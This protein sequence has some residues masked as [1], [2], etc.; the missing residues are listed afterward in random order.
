[1]NIFFFLKKLFKLFDYSSVKEK[2]KKMYFYVTKG[3]FDT[4]SI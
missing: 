3:I 1:M 4:D 2:S